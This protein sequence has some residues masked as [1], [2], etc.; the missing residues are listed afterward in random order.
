[1][2]NIIRSEKAPDSLSTPAIQKY[3]D[4]L[5]AYYDDQQLPVDQRSLAKPEC[6]SSYRKADLFNDFDEC[7][8]KKCYLTEQAFISS[9]EMDVEHFI[10]RNEKPELTYNWGNLYPADHNANMMKPRKTP[11]GGYLD[12]CDPTDDVEKELLYSLNF[13]GN[14]VDIGAF[15]PSNTK[16][17][18]TAKL[19]QK[20]HNGDSFEGKQKT[21]GLR[22]AIRVKHELVLNTIIKWQH[23]CKEQNRKE[24]FLNESL[25]KGYLSRESAFTMV[26]RSIEAVKVLPSDFLD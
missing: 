9:Y 11:P 6:S 8:F 1:M 24:E 17:V 2:I 20:L 14:R 3:L 10:P 4:D 16:A 15:D 19:L 18:N 25:L 5:D 12:P 7:F 26:L 21:L 22:N 13:E 23:A